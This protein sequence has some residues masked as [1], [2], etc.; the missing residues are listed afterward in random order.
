[1][2]TVAISIIVAVYK[3]EAYLHRCIDSLLAQ[4]FTDFEIL[5]IDD[6]SPDRSGEICDEYAAKDSRIRVIHKENGGV[7]SARQCGLDNAQGEYTIHADPDDWVEPDML[8][9]LY[10]KAKK[11]NADMVICDFYVNKG[12]KQHYVSQHPLSIDAPTVL[13]QVLLQQLHGSCCNKLVKRACYSENNVKFPKE[14]S[15]CEDLVFNTRLLQH[16][17]CIRYLQRAFYHYDQ[18]ANDHSIV[19]NY[20]MKRYEEDCH[21]LKIVQALPL[22]NQTLQEASDNIALEIAW[23]AFNKKLFSANEFKR[24]FAKYKNAAVRHQ[25][26][27]YRIFVYAACIGLQNMVHPLSRL[28]RWGIRQIRPAI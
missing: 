16:T 15:L 28:L 7:S 11:E 14:V 17:K 25:E 24:R 23:R 12:N 5:L 19:R 27:K 6:G 13:R 1:M 2:N 21:L 26:L 20:S 9:E 22:D 4:T 3:A 18:T 8:E 10:K